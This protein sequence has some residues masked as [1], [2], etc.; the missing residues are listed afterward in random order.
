V[1][2]TAAGEVLEPLA[3]RV[4][5]DV[6]DAQAAL[7][8][9]AGLRRGRLRLG[10]IQALALP[11]RP[12][13]RAVRVPRRLSGVDFHLV[14]AP[15]FEMATAV[16]DGRLDVALVGLGPRQSRTSRATCWAATARCWS[17]TTS[18]R[19]PTGPS[20]TWPDLPATTSHPALRGPD[21][22]ARWKRPSPA[23]G[24]DPGQHFEV[25]QVYDM[26]QSPPAA[27]A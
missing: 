8:A 9:L 4:L 19:S 22:A 5:A 3:R 10:L 12:G 17:C 7:D 27:W 15:S 20:R 16:L 1:R 13:H 2:L 6:D 21:C 14:N 11:D 26:V 24:V 25:G 23:A 18:P